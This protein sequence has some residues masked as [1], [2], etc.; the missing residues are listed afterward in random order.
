MARSRTRRRPNPWGRQDHPR[1]RLLLMLEDAARARIA[2]AE[3][4]IE[5][6]AAEWAR[7]RRLARARADLS[8][9]LEE[10]GILEWQ[11]SRGEALAA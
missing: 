3:L 6:G 11:E 7:C 10:I 1:K 4:E 5:D 8:A 2:R 9:V